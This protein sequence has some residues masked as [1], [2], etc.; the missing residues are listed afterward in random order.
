MAN[1]VLVA[2]AS[3][4][5]ST[6]EV[7]QAIA[8]RLD[9]CGIEG[10]LQPMRGV[11]SLAGYSA[12]VLGA[13]LY[14]FHWHRDALSFLAQHREALKT[15]AVAVFALGPFHDDP[16]EW[17]E[18]RS[19]LDKDLAK[20]PWFRPAAIKIIGAK[21]DPAALRFPWNCLPA[22]KQMPASD[23]RDWTA[24]R[25]WAGDL[26]GQFQPGTE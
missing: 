15:M 19:E 9:E 11:R 7:A 1:K 8:A 18:A 12:A 14:M 2:Y 10:D 21:F 3:K 17:A 5:G 4:Y 16:K 22:L 20:F 6:H 25:N 13:P 24:I 26:A 23:L